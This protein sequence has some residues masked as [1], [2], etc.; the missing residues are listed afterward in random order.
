MKRRQAWILSAGVVA[1]IP[2]L[3]MAQTGPT[4]VR[5][6]FAELEAQTSPVGF[7][8]SIPIY[9]MRIA[10]GPPGYVG[11]PE[12]VSHIGEVLAAIDNSD[13]RNRL[14]QQ[15]LQFSRQ[16]I[17][18]DQELQQQWLRLQQQQLAQQ[19]EADQLRFQVAQLQMRIEELRVQNLRLE[20]ENL[21]ARQ[22]LAPGTNAQVPHT[23]VPAPAPQ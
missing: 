19:Q 21:Q 5:A 10:Y 14:A 1:L 11:T 22:Q 16:T 17:A 9:P 3:A 2:L 20:Q 6:D 8:G 12:I 15:W 18:K 23:S 7:E 13:D 4:R